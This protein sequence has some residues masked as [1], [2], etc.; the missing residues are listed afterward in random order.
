MNPCHL[1][2]G[3]VWIAYLGALSILIERGG[4]IQ[5]RPQLLPETHTRA[6]APHLQAIGYEQ[7]GFDCV[8]SDPAY[9]TCVNAVRLDLISSTCIA[10]CIATLLMAVFA[11]MP[12][13]VAPAMGVNAFFTYNVVGF[14]GTGFISYPQVC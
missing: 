13:A 8:F 12:I 1:S 14:R 9:A 6:R 2:T 5:R 3:H 10:A 11:K 4:E 7:A